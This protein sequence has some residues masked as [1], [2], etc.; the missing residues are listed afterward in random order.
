MSQK[1][2]QW[3]QQAFAFHQDGRLA[4]AQKLYL[5]LLEQTPEDP[6]PYY[7]LAT[8]KSQ[9]QDHAGALPL[10]ERALELR[11]GH[12]ET[13]NNL[14]LAL[15]HSDR[16]DEAVTQLQHAI[17][18]K[19]DYAHAHCNLGMAFVKLERHQ[20][21]TDA[22]R[23][24]VELDPGYVDAQFNLGL[25]LY[26]LNQFAEAEAP[27]RRTI[28]LCPEHAS[29]YSD[30]GLVLKAMNR[31]SEAL[32][33]FERL[34]ALNPSSANPWINYGATLLDLSRF[35]EALAAFRR[36]ESLDPDAALPHW[37]TAYP[38]LG[39]GQLQEGWE[40]YEWRWK[41]NPIL[42]PLPYPEWEGTSLK[43][44]TILVYAEQGLGDELLFASCLPDL[45]RRA[46]HCVIECEPRLALLY[47]RSFPS[48]TVR[49]ARRYDHRWINS[50][51]G[52]DVQCALDSLPRY[53]RREIN[54]FP[55]RQTAYL[56]AEPEACQTWLT[57]LN[58][59][60]GK[61]KIGICW[62]SGL[63]KGERHKHYT[64]LEQWGSIFAVPE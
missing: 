23:R 24:A 32:S 10:F 57:W 51:P 49:G 35:E 11:P 17:A 63:M 16:L 14:G 27:L 45:I 48:A 19:P 40:A 22:Y 2:D 8:L 33:C 50:V 20:A 54:Q 44:K 13:L 1:T 56:F 5:R 37:N 61:I 46:D 58:R 7:L 21:A 55:T 34:C 12:P 18:A 15:I 62:R 28:E 6:E 26:R 38:L 43:G 36:A 39:L 30:L 4:E 9:Q 41:I 52:C 53:L 29:A 47:S 60:A 3:F 42:Y 25:S 31:L 64:R 59:L